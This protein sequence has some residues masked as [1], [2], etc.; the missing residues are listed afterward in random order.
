[1]MYYAVFELATIGAFVDLLTISSLA[2]TQELGADN[3]Q[4]HSSLARDPGG[5]CGFQ[6][7]WR[8]RGHLMY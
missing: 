8:V 2:Q 1:M 6:K 3:P 4:L 7:L 5:H